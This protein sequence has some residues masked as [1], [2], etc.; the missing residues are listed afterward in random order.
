MAPFSVA[1]TPRCRGGRYSF[2]WM[3]LYKSLKKDRLWHE[4]TQQELT[5]HKTNLPTD[6][7]K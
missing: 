1:T 6:K 3:K 4:I 7:K 5:Y 2:P